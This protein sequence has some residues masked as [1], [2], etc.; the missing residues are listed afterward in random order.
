MIYTKAK[1]ASHCLTELF[2]IYQNKHWTI[3]RRDD[4]I[5]VPSSNRIKLKIDWFNILHVQE[6]QARKPEFITCQWHDTDPG[7]DE[8]LDW[9]KLLHS[10]VIGVRPA[11]PGSYLD[12][13]K[14]NPAA[15]AVAHLWLLKWVCT[16]HKYIC[17]MNFFTD[18]WHFQLNVRYVQ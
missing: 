13:A 2:S 14:Y 3:R 5:I 8:A 10:G 4:H 7:P 12:F 16:V 18:I 9:Q 17:L 1:P 6:T 15:A 11:R